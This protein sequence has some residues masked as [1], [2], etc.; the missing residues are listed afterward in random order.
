MHKE[1]KVNKRYARSFYTSFSEKG[2]PHAHL[3]ST[4]RTASR[5]LYV[6]SVNISSYLI[7]SC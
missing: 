7:T 5:T 3:V 1:E 4:I 2:M 6:M